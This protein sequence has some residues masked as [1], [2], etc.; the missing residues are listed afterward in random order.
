MYIKF[1]QYRG[2]RSVKTMHTNL[3]A[4]IS[5]KVH[6]CQISAKSGQEDRQNRKHTK[7][8]NCINLQLAI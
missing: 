6:A 2:C 8:L 1:Q 3:F 7:K 5:H 4:K